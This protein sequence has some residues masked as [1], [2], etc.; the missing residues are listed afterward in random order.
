MQIIQLVTN[1]LL[2]TVDVLVKRKA[3]RQKLQKHYYLHINTDV[4]HEITYIL[5]TNESVKYK[6]DSQLVQSKD[7]IFVKDYDFC[8]LLKICAKTLVKV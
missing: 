2:S 8:L 5:V 3:K 7:Q 4:E 1:I 6:N